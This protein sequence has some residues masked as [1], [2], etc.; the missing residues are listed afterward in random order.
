VFAE[1][2]VEVSAGSGVGRADD[3]GVHPQPGSGREAPGESAARGSLGP[4]IGRPAPSG[5][6]HQTARS[7]GG[8]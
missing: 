7:A 5:G 1:A 3:T 6:L 8:S 2:E 4:F